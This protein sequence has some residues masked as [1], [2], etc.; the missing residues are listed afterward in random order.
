ML[1]LFKGFKT[2]L[3][4]LLFDQ[5]NLDV[6]DGEGVGRIF[7]IREVCERGADDGDGEHC[8]AQ[9]ECCDFLFHVMASFQFSDSF[10]EFM[11]LCA[12]VTG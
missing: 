1:V 10:A 2:V 7:G 6:A 11:F 9:A 12:G 5:F 8:C 4:A 3:A